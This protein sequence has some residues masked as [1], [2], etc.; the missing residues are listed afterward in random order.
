MTTYRKYVCAACGH[1][2]DE[3]FGDPASGVAPGARWE[4]VPEDWICP[5]CG[6]DKSFY[7]LT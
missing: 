4:D 2:Y 3:E 5:E 7:D 6:V 1:V